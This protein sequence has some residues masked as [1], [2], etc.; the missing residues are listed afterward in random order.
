MFTNF[1]TIILLYDDFEWVQIL[2]Y[3]Y[4]ILQ[5]TLTRCT[6]FFKVLD[7]PITKTFCHRRLVFCYFFLWP[8]HYLSLFHS[9]SL[10]LSLSRFFSLSPSLTHSLF[11]LFHS[12]LSFFVNLLSYPAK[13]SLQFW[14][15][16]HLQ[17]YEL[18]L[19]H[20]VLKMANFIFLW[21]SK[22]QI[23]Q[24]YKYIVH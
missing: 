13:Y 21:L 24:K 16:S 1:S 14:V 18:Q 10:T 5:C 6:W 8:W 4:S 23:F 17:V 9:L 3:K 22:F 2:D 11:T 15:S 19:E 7:S 12:F 20:L